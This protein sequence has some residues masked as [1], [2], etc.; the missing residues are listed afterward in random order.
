MVNDVDEFEACINCGAKI[1]RN[2]P[3][4]V[5]TLS[6]LGE[7][8]PDKYAQ[9]IAELEGIA[10]ELAQEY[11]DHKMGHNCKNTRPLCPSCGSPLKTW[12]AKYCLKCNWRR[13][14]G[15]DISEYCKH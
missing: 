2:F 14:Q 1:H 8:T 3:V 10:L 4:S 6:N 15:N 7:L 9:R 5:K 12:R 13:D 11:V